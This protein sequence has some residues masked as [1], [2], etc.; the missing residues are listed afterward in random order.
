MPITWNK[1]E[2]K[3][4]GADLFLEGKEVWFFSV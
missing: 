2:M 4:Q 3:T 1:T